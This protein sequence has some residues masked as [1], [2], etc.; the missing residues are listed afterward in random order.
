MTPAQAVIMVVTSMAALGVI[1]GVLAVPGGVAAQQAIIRLIGDSAGTRL[2]QAII[3]VYPTPQL[4][5][6]LLSG[7]AIAVLGA[8]LPA[9]Q[10][11]RISTTS[12]L[13]TE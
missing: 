10:A 3:D 8:L 4:A 9:W 13:H 1:G 12:A 2:P 5:A 11:A 6:L 7:V